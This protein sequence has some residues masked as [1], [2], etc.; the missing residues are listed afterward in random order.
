[1]IE[2]IA[3]ALQTDTFELFSVQPV[4]ADEA[5]KN[6]KKKILAEVGTLVSS[7]L[8]SFSAVIPLLRRF[9]AVTIKYHAFKTGTVKF[10]L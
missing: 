9:F 4:P 7:H 1:M 6:L 2:R 8:K 3:E 5:I 10:P